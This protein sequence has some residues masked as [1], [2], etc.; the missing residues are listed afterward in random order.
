M[1][2]AF[3][4]LQ[5][6]GNDFVLLIEDEMADSNP[7][8]F[9]DFAKR[10]SDRRRGIG[11]DQLII[12]SPSTDKVIFYN[13]DGSHAEA[14]G[15]GTRCCAF[16]ALQY[17]K[18]KT[19]GGGRG[20]GERRH[21]TLHSFAGDLR[22]EITSVMSVR[23]QMPSIT[24]YC[25]C[26]IEDDSIVSRA[27]VPPTFVSLGN[28]HLILFFKSSDDVFALIEEYGEKLAKAQSGH[29]QLS[30]GVNVGFASIAPSGE[31]TLAVFERGA[32]LTLACGSNATATA[33][34]AYRRR[35]IE[36]EKDIRVIQRGGELS[37][38]VADGDNKVFMT[39]EAKYVFKGV[40]NL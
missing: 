11:F 39:G 29:Q 18:D 38:D 13:S 17:L 1:E 14:C 5:G 8:F 3:V 6:L 34:T 28:P 36:K 24:E 4:K 21:I 25:D 35:L 7:A 12:Y 32:G 19:S 20:G 40:V 30:Q 2:V 22:C 33:F 15:N 23:A 9:A 31:I 16:Y 26:R 10:F 27:I 37:I